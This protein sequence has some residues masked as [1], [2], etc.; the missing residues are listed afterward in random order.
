MKFP[1]H[2]LGVARMACARRAS[3]GTTRS[4]RIKLSMRPVSGEVPHAAR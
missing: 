1:S 4:I 2:P 3:V